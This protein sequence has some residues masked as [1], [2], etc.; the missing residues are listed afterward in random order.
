MFKGSAG[1]IGPLSSQR[2]HETTG[3]SWEMWKIGEILK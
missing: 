1:S 2:K 3:L